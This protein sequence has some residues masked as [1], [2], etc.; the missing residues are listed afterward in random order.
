MFGL[1]PCAD[2]PQGTFQPKGG[3]RGCKP[4][5]DGKATVIVGATSVSQCMCT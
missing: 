1:Q 2:C 5:P 4:C 3:K